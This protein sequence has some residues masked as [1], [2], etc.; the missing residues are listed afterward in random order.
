IEERLPVIDWKFS[1][2]TKL[3]LGYNCQGAEAKIRG[4]NFKVFFTEKIPLTKGPWIFNGLPGAILFVENEEKT[5]KIEAI[6]ISAKSIS[7]KP[8]SDFIKRKDSYS[9]ISRDKYIKDYTET[10]ER[11]RKYAKS[12]SNSDFIDSMREKGFNV[13]VDESAFNKQPPP[14]SIELGKISEEKK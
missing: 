14:A 3:I 8:L 5:V 4:Y 1:N 7:T 6:S 12:K 2:E 11:E 9:K 10:L 13:S